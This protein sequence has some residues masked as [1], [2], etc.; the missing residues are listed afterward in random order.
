MAASPTIRVRDGKGGRSRVVPAHPE[1]VEAFRSIPRWISQGIAAAD[2]E[3]VATAVSKGRA[4][5]ACPLTR[6]PNQECP[7]SPCSRAFIQSPMLMRTGAF[8]TAAKTHP[9]PTTTPA[10]FESLS[11][12][13]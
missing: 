2:L 10:S 4:A 7:R 1:L 5:T 9:S 6:Y 8:G 11:T 3:T 12:D 13:D